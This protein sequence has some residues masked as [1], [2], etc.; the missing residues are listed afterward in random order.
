MQ[1]LIKPLLAK[2]IN[3]SKLQFP[4]MISPK[5]DGAFAFIQSGKLFARSLKQHENLFTNTKY[6]NSAFNGLRGEIIAGD[7]PVAPDLCRNTGSNIRRI[8]GNP[9]STLWCFDYV[10]PETVELAYEARIK[11]LEAKVLVLNQQGFSFI[12]MIPV[13]VVNT[14]EDYLTTRDNFLHNGFEGCVVRDPRLPHKEGRSSSTKA[15]LWRYKPYATAEIRVTS[16]IEEM[17]NLNEAKTNE[18]GRTERSSNQENLVGKGNLGAIVGYLLS[19]LLDCYGK[20]VAPE[21]TEITVATGSLSDKDRLYFW[22]NPSELVGHLVEF[23]YMSFGLKE[24]PRFAQFK[25]IRSELDI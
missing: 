25:Q 5:I 24:K 18:L 13:S 1:E 7:N 11:M 21:N 9:E 20:E 15:H 16:L 4:L 19:P 2:D 14:L 10:L 6:S 3:E 12:K 17:H 23:E 22:S 8:L